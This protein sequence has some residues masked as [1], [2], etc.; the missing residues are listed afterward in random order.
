MRVAVL[1]DIHGSLPSLEAALHAI[2]AQPVDGLLVAGDMTCGPNSS[3]VLRRLQAENACMVLGNNEGYL[4]RFDAGQAPEWWHTSHQWAF[5]RWVYRT[6]DR[7]SLDLL[8]SLPEQRVIDLPGTTLIRMFHGSLRDSREMLDPRLYPE[9]LKDA[10]SR[11][12]EPVL[13]CG[14]THLPWQKRVDGRLAFNPGA[15][16]FP[17]N[18]DPGAQYAILTWGTSAWEVEHFSAPYDH[19]LVRTDFINSGLLQEGGA[20][21][22]AF[23]LSI[24]YGRDVAMNFLNYAY[25]KAAEAGYPDCEYVPD[26]IWD[27]AAQSFDWEKEIT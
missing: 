25:R 1:A 22:R 19:S 2:H 14:H 5:N 21:A 12:S 18:G 27:A 10:F 23:L 16:T 6:I 26:G 13:I 8:H 9:P 24:E 11:T 15:V 20:L 7:A 3:E 17:C 4:L